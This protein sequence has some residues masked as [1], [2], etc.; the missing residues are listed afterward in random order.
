M[1]PVENSVGE[2]RQ[3]E[4]IL[5]RVPAFRP[6]VVK[7][8]R[9]LGDDASSM[10]QVASL[11]SSDP[12]L[13]A[14]VL[15]AANSAMYGTPRRI[16]TTKH[17]I[18][19]LGTERTK[20]LAMRASLDAMQRSIGNHPAIENCWLH[21]RAAAVVAQWLGP[22]FRIHPEWAYTAGLMHDVGRLGLLSL[23]T[24]GYAQLLDGAGSTEAAV[25]DDERSHFKMD[26]CEA[27]AW[28]TRAWGFPEDLQKTA[29]RHHETALRLPDPGV[30]LTRLSCRLA[31]A[32]GYKAAPSVELP[33]PEG[34]IEEIPERLRRE[35]EKDAIPAL[36]GRIEKEVG[37]PRPATPNQSPVPA[38]T[39]SS[40]RLTIVRRPSA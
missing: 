13:S 26:H 17:A 4:A 32:L 38:P 2:A 31:H 12:G 6:V 22:L 20:T 15:T 9:V 25:M 35:L 33:E 34:L 30:D 5:C 28:L 37:A 8:L 1:R 36:T 39:I 7:L 3:K 19:M 40:S 16:S 24:K 11:L 29:S 14:E 10:S 18:M 23:D 21:S 27:G